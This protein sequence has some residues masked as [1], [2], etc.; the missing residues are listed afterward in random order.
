MGYETLDKKVILS[1]SVNYS[2]NTKANLEANVKTHKFYNN[3]FVRN[4]AETYKTQLG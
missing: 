3:W 4:R 1:L 2:I